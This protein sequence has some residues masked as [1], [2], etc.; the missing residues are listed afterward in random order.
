MNRCPY[1][2]REIADGVCV[3]PYADCGQSQAAPGGMVG[4]IPLPPPPPVARAPPVAGQNAAVPLAPPPPGAGTPSPP[5]LTG[6]FDLMP[7]APSGSGRVDAAGC[8]SAS[9]QWSA[10]G[11]AA[12]GT[13]WRMH[14]DCAA[15]AARFR[16]FA[17]AWKPAFGRAGVPPVA[18]RAA[19]SVCAPAWPPGL[20]GRVPAQLAQAATPGRV[21]EQISPAPPPPP[22]LSPPRSMGSGSVAGAAIDP[23]LRQRLDGLQ[24]QVRAGQRRSLWL[25]YATAAALLVGLACWSGYH[26]SEVYRYAELDPKL[27]IGRDPAD[28]D[29]LSLVYCPVSGGEVGFRRTDVDRETEL[30]DRVGSAMAGKSQTFQWRVSG[31]KSGD[32]I[33]VTYRQG[34][35][36]VTRELI[37][38]DRPKTDLRGN[39]LLTGQIV[40]ALDK[41][42]VPGAK[43]RILGTQLSSVTDAQGRFRLEG[44]RRA[45][46]RS[47]CRPRSSPRK[48]SSGNWRRTR[49]RR[50]AWCS[51]RG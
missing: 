24:K 15:T 41:S 18:G 46:C 35:S 43:V 11:Q 25:A 34:L 14:V 32:P 3:C 45:A 5:A 37:V 22:G 48:S 13:W 23:A 6:L 26:L 27:Q 38:P 19:P 44:R 21:G 10:G 17:S 20:T 47:R 9:A 39:G 30:L 7:P 42:P 16:A 2:Q 29:R 8:W 50:S 4:N 51:A 40:N 49:R 36:L 33:R 12:C 31:V 28:A 1:C